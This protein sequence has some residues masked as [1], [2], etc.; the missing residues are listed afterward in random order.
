[1]LKFPRRLSVRVVA[2]MKHMPAVAV[3][4]PRQ[5]GKSTLVNDWVGRQQ[6]QGWSYLT[7]DDP[8]I[9]D[10]ALIDPTGFVRGQNRL[11]IDEI[12]RAPDLVLAVK[13]SID[14]DRRPGRF[15]VTGSSD[16]RTAGKINESLAGRVLPLTLLPLAQAEIEGDTT[17]RLLDT[18]LKSERPPKPAW[19]WRD[20]LAARITIGGYPD[21]VTRHNQKDRRAWM[22]AYAESVLAHDVPE[23]AGLIK[24]AEFPKLLQAAA[25]M[26]GQLLNLES[27]SNDLRLARGTV[28][29]YLQLLE[30]VWLLQRVPAWSD[31][32]MTRIV[33]SPK[34]QFVDSGLLCHLLRL[35]A[36]R[37]SEDRTKLGPVLECF[38]YS[39]LRKLASWRDDPI[40]IYHY[41]DRDQVEVDFVLEDSNGDIVAVEV[42][43]AASVAKRDFAGLEKIRV[44]AKAPFRAGVILYDGENVVPFGDRLWAVPLSCLWS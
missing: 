21:M 24:G 13:A 15:I 3:L 18:L 16:F 19:S 5:A 6:N 12:Q 29:R 25:A 44:H 23:I 39:E 38:V 33:K 20:D 28:S 9:R 2:E 4:G 14:T 41:R 10:A 37:L 7:L 34:I 35:D 40:Q 36:A 1:M 30:Q 27:L 11:A 8:T 17:P 43:A 31:R 42:K 32:Q 26:N 22:S